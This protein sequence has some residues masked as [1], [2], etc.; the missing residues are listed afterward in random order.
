MP[1]WCNQE[2]VNPLSGPGGEVLEAVG[3][4]AVIVWRI[5][6]LSLRSLGHSNTSRQ[7][8]HHHSG[9]ITG[10]KKAQRVNTGP[11]AGERTA[12]LQGCLSWP[13]LRFQ[14]ATAASRAPSP[15]PSPCA[16]CPYG[17][18][19]VG[20]P[21]ASGRAA[22]VSGPAPVPCT[23]P[24]APGGV[25]GHPALAAGR[26]NG[27]GCCDTART[28]AHVKRQSPWP[29]HGSCQQA[30]GTPP[31]A[32]GYA[33]GGAACLGPQQLQLLLKLG[34]FLFVLLLLVS[35]LLPDSLFG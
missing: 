23:G 33:G 30:V 26:Q 12:Q 4:L 10:S 9:N 14:A 1:Q 28:S 31:S 29:K 16:S 20:P 24:P 35:Q 21:A 34:S 27:L 13:H 15:C 3:G 17:S 7:C 5:A 2:E 19:A 6:W 11:A 8:C 32:G 18:P 22:A 25:S